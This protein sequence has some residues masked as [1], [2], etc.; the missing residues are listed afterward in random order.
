MS[1]TLATMQTE[2]S[3]PPLPDS[4]R[5]PQAPPDRLIQESQFL[6]RAAKPHENLTIVQLYETA[7]G[8]QYT[9]N[10]YKAWRG[11]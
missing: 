9:R 7:S 11:L 10:F 3:F 6:N 5:G 1:L 2:Y 8:H 4:I